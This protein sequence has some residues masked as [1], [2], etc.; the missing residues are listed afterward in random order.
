MCFS[1]KRKKNMN[2]KKL[3]FLVLSMLLVSPMLLEAKK[4][5][6]VSKATQKRH[7][8]AKKAAAQRAALSGDV[9]KNKSDVDLVLNTYNQNINDA[10][11]AA[12]IAKIDGFISYINT[13][14]TSLKSDN[15]RRKGNN[16]TMKNGGS[17][18]GIITKDEKKKRESNNNQIKENDKSIADNNAIKNA[19]T[20]YKEIIKAKQPVTVQTVEEILATPTF[21]LGKMAKKMAEAGVSVNQNMP[22]GSPFAPKQ[23]N[24]APFYEQNTPAYSDEDYGFADASTFGD[25]TTFDYG[26]EATDMG[27]ADMGSYETDGGYMTSYADQ[28]DESDFSW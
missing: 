14:N 12:A 8:D 9:S 16:K 24:Q 18:A 27:S 1:K 25:D 11:K 21:K 13:K 5:K 10:T 19:Y 17:S 2:I 3:Q 4:K 23:T 28:A 20:N 22:Q 7:K 6:I 26:A 15:D